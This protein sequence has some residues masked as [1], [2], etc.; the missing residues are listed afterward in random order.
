[1]RLALV[2]S[3]LA[4]A[5]CHPPIDKASDDAKA[6]AEA[7]AREEMGQDDPNV[8]FTPAPPGPPRTYEAMSKTAMSFTPGVLTVLPTAQISENMPPGAVFAFGNGITY[9]TTL[10]PG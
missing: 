10:N 6:A 2:V 8:P 1:M 7:K 5:A 4:L 9:Q 3:L